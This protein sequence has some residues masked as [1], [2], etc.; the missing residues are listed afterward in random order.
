MSKRKWGGTTGGVSKKARQEVENKSMVLYKAPRRKMTFGM[1]QSQTVKLRY[2]DNFTVDPGAGVVG[3]H[4]MSANGI[5]DPNI[6]GTGHQPMYFDQYAAIYQH[7][8]VLGA[9]ITA[10][11]STTSTSNAVPRVWGIYL[12]DN[13]GAL[14]S[15]VASE[16][17]ELPT[18]KYSFVNQGAAYGTFPVKKLVHTFSARKFFGFKDVKDNKGEF[19]SVVSSNPIDQAYF[20]I[21]A[22]AQNESDDPAAVQF[23]VE[24]DYIVQFSELQT[25]TPS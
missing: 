16:L 3:A 24:I 6:T 8:V 7:Y 9:K 18:T 17:M 12:D 14:T 5:Y 11:A 2:V 1:P 4:F 25:T 22:A 23:M 10:W 15:K 19:G 13:A 20:A 21:W